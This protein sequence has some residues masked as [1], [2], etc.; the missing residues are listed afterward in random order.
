M[1]KAVNI[2]LIILCISLFLLSG[3]LV[4]VYF[5]NIIEDKEIEIKNLERDMIDPEEAEVLGKLTNRELEE[6][7]M[8][9]NISYSNI[10]V[11]DRNFSLTSVEEAKRFNEETKVQYT[12]AYIG[13]YDCDEFAAALY[14]YWNHDR[15]QFAFGLAWSNTHAF[16]VMIDEN[17]I[18]WVIEPQKNTFFRYEDVDEKYEI[19]LFVII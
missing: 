18:L 9:Y 15:K 10:Y 8:S 11:S 4:N 1:R 14:G 13:N 7:L 5:N 3:F 12:L 16:N 6:I 19:S 17:R 2:I